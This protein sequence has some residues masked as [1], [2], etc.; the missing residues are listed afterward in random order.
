MIAAPIMNL[1]LKDF[2]ETK[3]DI[4]ILYGGRDL[5]KPT[6]TA[7]HSIRLTSNIKLKFLCPN[8]SKPN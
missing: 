4:K 8:V 1:N 2:W 5:Q 3:S 7:I 6:D